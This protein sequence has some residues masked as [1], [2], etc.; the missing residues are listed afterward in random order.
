MP[1]LQGADGPT[2]RIQGRTGNQSGDRGSY[3]W[4]PLLCLEISS[5]PIR[6][7]ECGGDGGAFSP[8]AVAR[9]LSHNITE[10]KSDSAIKL[11]CVKTWIN[12]PLL[13]SQSTGHGT[14]IHM[15]LFSTF[16]SPIGR[17]LKLKQLLGEN[18]AE[19]AFG[20]A[21]G[22]PNSRCFQAHSATHKLITLV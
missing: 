13:F 11:G 17:W 2:L 8:L 6:S 12:M 14:C 10:T 1:V 19:R 18:N 15:Q 16:S 3:H 5:Y 9:V 21:F 7:L 20:C 22:L 4:A